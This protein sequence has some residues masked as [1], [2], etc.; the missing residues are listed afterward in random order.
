MGSPCSDTEKESKRLKLFF[1]VL[2]RRELSFLTVPPIRLLKDCFHDERRRRRDDGLM[3]AI[4]V[5]D[6]VGMNRS[7]TT[8]GSE[9]LIFFKLHASRTA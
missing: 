9:F 8:A 4:V 1:F 7:T 6:D 5:G 2:F 3:T